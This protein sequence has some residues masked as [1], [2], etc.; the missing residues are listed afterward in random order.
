MSD[1]CDAALNLPDGDYPCGGD[2][3]HAEPHYSRSA[4][5]GWE[6]ASEPVIDT[7]P[8]DDRYAALVAAI[9][10][11]ADRGRDHGEGYRCIRD[12]DLRAL[13]DGDGIE[14]TSC[15]VCGEERTTKNLA[16]HIRR[17]HG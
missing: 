17:M 11:L 6:D 12:T 1:P 2:Q 14:R 8:R 10:A 4:G 16:R 7:R 13:I 15:P 9:T 5:V 3:G